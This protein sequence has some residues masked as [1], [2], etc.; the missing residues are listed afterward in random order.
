[1]G[2]VPSRVRRDQNELG[3]RHGFLAP[4]FGGVIGLEAGQGTED[5]PSVRRADGNSR[6]MSGGAWS[7]DGSI[8]APP[9]SAG[10]RPGASP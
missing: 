10:P 8:A 4:G 1:M 2:W 9:G 7:G 5:S 6:A 3:I